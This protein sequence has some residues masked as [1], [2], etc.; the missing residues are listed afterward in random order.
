M[1][2]SGNELILKLLSQSVARL[3]SSGRKRKQEEEEEIGSQKVKKDLSEAVNTN[4]TIIEALIVYPHMHEISPKL[5][6]ELSS[7]HIFGIVS[8]YLQKVSPELAELTTIRNKK[9][10]KQKHA[11][12]TTGVI[13]KKFTKAE[14]EVLHTAIKQAGKEIDAASLAKTLDRPFKSVVNRINSLIRTAALSNP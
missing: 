1:P 8:K 2:P 3:E 6:E 11:N 14:D 10:D 4:N 5:A 12:M 13:R 9:P 7:L